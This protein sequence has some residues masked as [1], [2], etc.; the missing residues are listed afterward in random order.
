MFR[1][2]LPSLRVRPRVRVPDHDANVEGVRRGAV[3]R[4]RHAR[5]A[6]ASWLPTAIRRLCTR[7]EEP[8]VL[9]VK[10]TTHLRGSRRSQG[11]R[12]V[13]AARLQ[14]QLAL[15]M[16]PQ[17]HV[18]LHSLEARRVWPSVEVGEAA[19]ELDSAL[20]LAVT[21]ATELHIDLLQTRVSGPWRVEMVRVLGQD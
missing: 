14:A 16:V 10:E 9:S 5:S 20:P 1:M 11:V 3:N 2:R 7:A 4:F 13:P 15:A 21:D 19:V 6:L 18:H 8:R 17:G 12:F